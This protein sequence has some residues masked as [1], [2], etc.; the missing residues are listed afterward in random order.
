[1][2]YAPLSDMMLHEKDSRMCST[3]WCIW[4]L[5]MK[6]VPSSYITLLKV[7]GQDFDAE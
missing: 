6:V 5:D 2:N 1:M 7:Y 4:N 3:A